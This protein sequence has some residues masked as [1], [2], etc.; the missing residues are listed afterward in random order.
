[1]LESPSRLEV[2]AGSPARL[3]GNSL[4]CRR[5]ARQR[6]F[7]RRV[8]AS[9]YL[10]QFRDKKHFRWKRQSIS[11]FPDQV[12]FSNDATVFSAEFRHTASYAPRKSFTSA[13]PARRKW[14]E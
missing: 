5:N 12:S 6:V 1:M 9:F 2:S 7:F 4:R 3:K 10:Q 8:A 14:G 11:T 13:V